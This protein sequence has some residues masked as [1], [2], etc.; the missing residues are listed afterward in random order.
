MSFQGGHF[1]WPSFPIY[2]ER[3]TSFE[4]L[5]KYSTSTGSFFLNDKEKSKEGKESSKREDKSEGNKGKS[6]KDI[7]LNDKEKA[8]ED[9]ESS[10]KED[11]SEGDKGRSAKDK[12]LN[13]M[14][15]SNEDDE[16]SKK[17]DKSEGNKGKLAKKATVQD[18][19]DDKV[20]GF[21]DEGESEGPDGGVT[22]DS[23]GSGRADPDG[24]EPFS[25][26]NTLSTYMPAN[27]DLCCPFMLLQ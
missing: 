1:N 8:D 22:E 26:Q 7:V 19:G 12:L 4:S 25:N 2:G 3:K 13:G 21:T 24:G 5:E 18:E 15:K 14:E 27:F 11:K 10:N 6:A 16:S 9:L 17:E 23:N 20:I